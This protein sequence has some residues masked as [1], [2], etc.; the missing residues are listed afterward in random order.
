MSEVENADSSTP[1]GS[2]LDVS[3]AASSTGSQADGSHPVIERSRTSSVSSQ[4]SDT[5]M[6]ASPSRTGRQPS[7]L[8]GAEDGVSEADNDDHSS[9]VASMNK[10]EL[11]QVYSKAL[12]R[13]QQ[14]KMR[15]LQV[16]NCNDFF[17]L[18]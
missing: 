3:L 9:V 16:R 4:A 18:I 7:S 2:L 14:Y 12:R 10:E 8:T 17:L 15:Y 1:V 5:S 11:H 13:G 6:L